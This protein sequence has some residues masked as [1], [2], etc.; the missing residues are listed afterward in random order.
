MRKGNMNTGKN[1]G[2]LKSA[3]KKAEKNSKP[4]SIPKSLS[5]GRNKPLPAI[6]LEGLTVPQQLALLR[7]TY[8]GSQKLMA[9]S[10]G[11]SNKSNHISLVETGDAHLSQPVL[12]KWLQLCFHKIQIVP[13]SAQEIRA[14]VLKQAKKK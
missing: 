5:S 8:V 13:M 1:T 11:M 9:Y 10:L 4:S 14:V 3:S 12:E 6:S 7:E 2:T